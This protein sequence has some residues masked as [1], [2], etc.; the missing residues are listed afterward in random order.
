MPPKRHLQSLFGYIPRTAAIA[1]VLALSAWAQSYRNDERE[2]ADLAVYARGST[3][4][5]KSVASIRALPRWRDRAAFV[6]AMVRPSRDY[7]G[8]R[9]AGRVSRLRSGF[10]QSSRREP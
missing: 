2:V 3:Y 8:T 4:A 10:A 6:H 7:L 5:E 9:H 1:S